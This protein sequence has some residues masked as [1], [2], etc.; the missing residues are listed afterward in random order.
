MPLTFA[1]KLAQTRTFTQTNQ[2]GVDSQEV[3]NEAILDSIN[4]ISPNG[5]G[6]NTPQATT[7]VT[8]GSVASGKVA[9][10][11]T[12]SSDFIGTILGATVT[13]NTSINLSAEIGSTLLSIAYTITTGSI[14]IV[15]I[16]RP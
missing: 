7:A 6:T 13:A 12:T 9:V 10:S 15:T 8:T 11:L 2:L 3:Y 1:Q 5:L 14:L 16:S 4:K